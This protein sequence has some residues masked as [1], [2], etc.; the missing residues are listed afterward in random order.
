MNEPIITCPNCKTEIRLTEQL[1]APL[2]AEERVRYEQTIENMRSANTRRES[3]LRERE[4]AISKARDEIEG[5]VAAKL[6]QA[7]AGIATEEARKAKLIA[8]SELGA[9]QREIAGLNEVLQDRDARLIEAQNAQLELT[10]EKRKLE[11]DRQELDLKAEQQVRE[12]LGEERLKIRSQVEDENKLTNMQ[13]DQIINSMKEQLAAAQ[14][15]AEQGS[16]QLQGE[17][18][19]LEL[20]DRLRS[21]FRSDMIEA[22]AK[23]ESGADVVQRV[24]NASGQHCGTILWE[25]K[26][27][28]NWSDGWLAKLRDDRREV[29]AEIAVIVS[30]AMPKNTESFDLIDDVWVTNR[31]CAMPVAVALRESLINLWTARQAADGQTT[32]TQLVYQYLT[33]PEFKQRVEAIVE[34]FREMRTDLESEKRAMQKQWAKREKLIDGILSS[35]AG[36]WGDLQGITARSLDEIEGLELPRLDAPKAA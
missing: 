26:R 28:K 25:S 13:K 18:Q 34:K 16:Q 30:R 27:T 3:E 15:K 10:R 32:K 2:L 8:D 29:K 14:R 20:E 11:R 36:M 5:Q 35:T 23:G 9:K 12:L 4:A 19:E 33:G 1:A 17:V 24:L 6:Q 21:R 7:R 22:V 31:Q